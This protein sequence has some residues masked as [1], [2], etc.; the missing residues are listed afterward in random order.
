MA[1]S[2][3]PTPHVARIDRWPSLTRMFF[4]QAARLGE[5]PFLWRKTGGAWQSTSWREASET[6]ASLADALVGLGIQPGDRVVLVSENR[7][8]FCIADLAVMAA[9]GATV[10]TYVTNTEADH[11]HI[12]ENSG[13]R[14]VIVSTQKLAL[15][16]RTAIVTTV[17]PALCLIVWPLAGSVVRMLRVVA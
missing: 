7:P 15:F 12:L 11:L 17:T 8:E 14:L 6:V 3:R 9:G 16:P 5:A 4:E 10:P 2:P 13:A 1:L